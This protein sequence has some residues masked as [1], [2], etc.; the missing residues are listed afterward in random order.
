[1]RPNESATCG[2]LDRIALR[3]A[4]SPGALPALAPV[5]SRPART[6]GEVGVSET[7]VVLQRG[8]RFPA[9]R[10]RST[11]QP[12]PLQQDEPPIVDSTFVLSAAAAGA[13]N[14]R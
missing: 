2:R 4:C 3:A 1:M 5:E 12:V 11:V 9:G 14:E 8:F 10:C 6:V 7:H 13:A